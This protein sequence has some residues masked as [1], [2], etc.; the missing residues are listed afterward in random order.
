M[1]RLHAGRVSPSFAGDPEA[2]LLQGE[3]LARGHGYTNPLIDI[4]NRSATSGDEP[5]PAAAVV[6]LPARLPGVRRGRS[7]WGRVAHADPRRRRGVAP[8]E[9]VQAVLGAVSI[10]LAFALARRLFDERV[11]LVAAAIVAL[12]PNLIT[13]TATRF[14]SRPSSSR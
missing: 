2:Y 10:L 14:N 1:G 6:V 8:V 5:L 9:Y 7:S 4:E 12:Y 3:T 11:A 13:T